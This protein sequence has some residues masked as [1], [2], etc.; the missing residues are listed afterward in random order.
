MVCGCYASVRSYFNNSLKRLSF[1]NFV[2]LQYFVNGFEVRM[3]M[4]TGCHNSIINK[5][6]WQQMGE[7]ELTH[8]SRLRKS[9]LGSVSIKGEFNAKITLAEEE[10]VLPIQVADNETTRSLLGRRCIPT[11][12]NINWNAFFNNRTITRLSQICRRTQL[13]LRADAMRYRSNLLYIN[14]VM[15][16]TVMVS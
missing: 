4:D 16:K 15:E 7:P 9:A 8:S 5:R 10:Y 12:L 1:E 3:K 11:L 6:I 2:E 13:K 14:L